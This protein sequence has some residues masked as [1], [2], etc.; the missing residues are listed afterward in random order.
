[1]LE[2]LQIHRFAEPKF[3][4]RTRNRSF[5]PQGPNRP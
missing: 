1:M 4:N 5:W 3:I 2:A